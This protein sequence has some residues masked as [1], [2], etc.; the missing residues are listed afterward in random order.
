M[1]RPP[2]PHEIRGSHRLLIQSLLLLAAI[3][4]LMLGSLLANQS[5]TV[6][7]VPKGPLA[8]LGTPA[9]V[10]F[11]FDASDPD[12]QVVAVDIFDNGGWI[13]SL[14]QRPFQISREWWVGAHSLRA[15][16]KDNEGAIGLSTPIPFTVQAPTPVSLKP[17]RREGSDLVLEWSGGNGPFLVEMQTDLQDAWTPL[18]MTGSNRVARVPVGG[19]NLFLQI[20]DTAISGTRNYDATLSGANVIPSPVDT[21]ATAA[22]WMSIYHS[23]VTFRIEYSGL[24]APLSAVR[25]HGPAATND[26][27]PA[28]F[29]LTAYHEGKVSTSGVLSGSLVL[30]TEQKLAF[31]GG[32]AYVTLVESGKT[33]ES[34]RGQLLPRPLGYEKDH[35]NNFTFL[36]C[37]AN[38][39]AYDTSGWTFEFGNPVVT[40][41]QNPTGNRPWVKGNSGGK[42]TFQLTCGR[43]N[44]SDVADEFRA[45]A[46]G[47]S[48]L[49]QEF[50]KMVAAHVHANGDTKIPKEMNF[51]FPVKMTTD[52]GVVLW[53][54]LGQ[55]GSGKGWL[56]DIKVAVEA[57]KEGYEA[58]K[59][60]DEGNLWDSFTSVVK[61]LSK[62]AEFAGLFTNAWTVAVVGTTGHPAFIADLKYQQPPTID[63][64]T[65][66]QLIAGGTT[67]NGQTQLFEIQPEVP[68]PSPEQMKIVVQ[69]PR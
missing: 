4:G 66:A 14:T 38:G 35:D 37:T 20:N 58:Y 11:E 13:T 41:G 8:D 10:T 19:T 30:S 28:M 67:G 69:S 50:P 32:Q 12:G 26:L 47:Y 34:L 3:P 27:A 46:F 56:G 48:A 22:V 40:T 49:D 57:A 36:V 55:N 23:T 2:H 5:P 68:Y 43:E 61:F 62:T 18:Q 6:T 63:T 33:T 59:D 60:A 9:I 39:S 31:L 29:D 25:M 1:K 51:F 44:N 42:T 53:M 64:Y 21:P 65:T 54:F 15:R 7:I 24:T 52:T 16:A 45:A 17:V